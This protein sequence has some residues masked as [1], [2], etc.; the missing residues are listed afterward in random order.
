MSHIP[1]A[2]FYT[3]DNERISVHDYCTTPVGITNYAQESSAEFTL[4]EF[5]VLSESFSQ[6]GIFGVIESVRSTLDLFMPL[7]AEEIETNDD[8]EVEPELLNSDP[9]EK[10]WLHKIRISNATQVDSLLR[11]EAYFQLV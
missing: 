4:F 8:V 5:S 3:K 2:V 9:Y 7:N 10:G 11:A 6:T 1:K